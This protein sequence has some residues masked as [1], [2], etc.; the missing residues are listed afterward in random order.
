MT[1]TDRKPDTKPIGFLFT[2]EKIL[3]KVEDIE[4]KLDD[5]LRKI[6]VQVAAMWVTHGIMVAIIIFLAT[7]G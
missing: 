4:D 1:E 6:E 3:E 2:L 5:R 7:K